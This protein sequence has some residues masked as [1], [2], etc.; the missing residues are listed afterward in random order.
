MSM[1]KTLIAVTKIYW[2]SEGIGKIQ[3]ASM[4]DTDVEGIVTGV[5]SETI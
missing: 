3:R 1:P 5:Y 2:T 4:D